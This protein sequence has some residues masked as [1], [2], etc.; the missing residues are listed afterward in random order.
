MNNIQIVKVKILFIK[1]KKPT[2]LKS[3]LLCLTKQ[4][5]GKTWISGKQ[6]AIGLP[7]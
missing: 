5:T 3:H 1:K 4:M 6:T 2:T 7:A